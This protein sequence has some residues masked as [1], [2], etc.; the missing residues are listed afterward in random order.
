MNDNLYREEILEHY[1]NPL[2]FGKL[3]K[4]TISSRQTNPFC[5]DDIS[6]YVQ[7]DK[8]IMGGIGF[9]GRG[10]AIS[11]AAASVLTEHAK[12]KNKKELT[13]FSDSDMLKLLGV[14]VSQTRKKCALLALAVLRD[15]LYGTKSKS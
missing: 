7:W 8:G 15:C 14:E 9:E 3:T 6:I 11:M 1:R 13:K 2:N 4:F 10:C 12:E 5:G